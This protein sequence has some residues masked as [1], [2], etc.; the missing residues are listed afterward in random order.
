METV[1]VKKS[2]LLQA[3]KNNRKAHRAIFEEAQIGYRAEAIK[4]IDKAL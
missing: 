1:N 2:E 3:L 4:L